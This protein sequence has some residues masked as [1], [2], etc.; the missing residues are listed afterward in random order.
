[1][2]SYMA[3]PRSTKDIRELAMFLRKSFNLENVAKFPI[4]EFIEGVMHSIDEEFYYEIVD[5]ETMGNIHGLACPDQHC[6]KIRE[7]VYNRC[8]KGYGR[9]RF[10]LAH[11]LGHYLMHN[12]G[13]TLARVGEENV[14]AYRNTEWQANT[15]AAELLMPLNLINTND[16]KE[17]SEKFGVSYSAAAIRAKKINMQ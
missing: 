16:V 11:E 7:D 5:V 6:I 15:F 13:V 1:M 3:K 17:I 2:A 14:Q 12:S 10:T 8:W 4:M 9:D